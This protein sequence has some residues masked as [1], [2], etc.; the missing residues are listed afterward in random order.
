MDHTTTF[1]EVPVEKLRWRCD[2]AT[3]PFETT[4]DISACEIVIGQEKGVKALHFGLRIP[5]FGYNIFITGT[6]GTG[7][8]SALNC[9]L[10]DAAKDKKIPEDI[11]YVNNFK[12]SDMPRV[13][14]FDA[15]QG[16]AF[17]KEMAD[18]IQA[19]KRNIPQIF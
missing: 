6:S 4:H 14:K 16:K 10:E 2:P 18:F 9:C 12:N 8:R 3:L 17:R 15:G 5:G 7:R 19:L 13:L 1:E 11:C